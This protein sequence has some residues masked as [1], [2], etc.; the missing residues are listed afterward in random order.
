[1]TP[2]EVEAVQRLVDL[3]AER[4]DPSEAPTRWC[5]CW[6]CRWLREVGRA[7]RVIPEL[8]A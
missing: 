4:M 6:S 1:M 3:A 7:R 8:Q 2:E 5:S